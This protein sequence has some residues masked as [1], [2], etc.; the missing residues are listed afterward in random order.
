[1]R[2]RAL[3]IGAFIVALGA[4]ASVGLYLGTRHSKGTPVAGPTIGEIRNKPKRRRPTGPHKSP[5]PIL[6]YHVVGPTPTGAA[7]PGLYV[8]RRDFAAQLSWLVQQG[9][10]AVTLDAV[11]RYWRG[12]E[13]LPRRPIVLSFDD[14]Y[15]EQ[16]T[17][18]EPLLRK[19]HWP[20]VLNLEYAQLVHEAL[21]GPMIHQM[22]ADGW[23]LD[24]HTM[25]HPDLTTVDPAALRWE[26]TRSRELLHRRFGV[27]VHFFC[28]P[29]GKFDARV[30]RAVR[31]AGYWGATTIRMGLARPSEMF[32]L[33]RIRVDSG[34]GPSELA[35]KLAEAR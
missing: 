30:V 8:R 34:D 19:R 9:Y 16:H 21:T 1:M 35:T 4:G 24:S 29:M 32:T 26:L 28:Y 31:A 33:A 6:M 11:D 7:F 2:G 22:L 3:V 12:L 27:P 14:G 15:R 25:T 17:I 20:A 13:R 18:A 5:V 10:H 23:E